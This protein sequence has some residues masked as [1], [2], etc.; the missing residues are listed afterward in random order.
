[1]RLGYWADL[2]RRFDRMITP[3][4]KEI[5]G[6]GVIEAR[7]TSGGVEYYYVT[8]TGEERLYG[9]EA[10]LSR[11]KRSLIL[12]KRELGALCQE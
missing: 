5:L 11:S 10:K 6:A 7:G 12:R 9:G 1:M 4:N 2:G 3:D 8:K